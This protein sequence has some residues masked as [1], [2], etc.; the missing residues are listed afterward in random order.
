MHSPAQK[1]ARQQ[2]IDRARALAPKF[3]PRADAAE[4]ARQ[5]PRELVEDMLAAGIARILMPARFGGYDL[6]FETWHDVVLEISKVDASH[7]WCASLIIHHAHLIAQYPEECQQAIWAK[8]PDVAIAAS[9][10]P[11]AQATRVDGGYR[12]LS[13]QNSTFA[14]G[15]NNSSWVMIGAMDLGGPTPEWLLLMVPPGEY[16]VRDVWFTA[17]MRGTGS[18]TI[19]TDNV[20]VPATRAVSL[21]DLRVGKAPGAAINKALIYSTPFFFYAPLT[22]VGPM[23][24]AAMGAYEHFREWTK[25]RKA[26]DGSAVAEKT[27]VQVRMATRRRR[28]RRRGDAVAARLAAA[29]HAGS[30]HGGTPGAIGP[31]LHARLGADGRGDRR[32]H[33]AQRDGGLRVVAID[34]ARLARRALRR[35]TRRVEPR[36]QLRKLRPHR[37][38]PAARSQRP[39]FLAAGRAKLAASGFREAV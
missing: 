10:A 6:D 38:R 19:I 34:P 9:F 24:G 32:A 15:V 12:R 28:S 2:V 30:D 11:R 33:G 23:V 25:P 16:T 21:A 4:E 36:Q 14:S 18:N 31:R 22:F 13:G 8:G 37:I 1:S 3:A 27:S 26:V 17:G 39:V 5:I 7:G 20:F 35:H 29:A